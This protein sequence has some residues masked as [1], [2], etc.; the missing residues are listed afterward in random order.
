VG[1]SIP[2]R[3]SAQPN[4]ILIPNSIIALMLGRMQMPLDE[5]DKAYCELTEKLFQ[6]SNVAKKIRNRL[7][8]HD[9]RVDTSYDLMR[10]IRDLTKETPE[11]DLKP[12]KEARI[13]P[14]GLLLKDRTLDSHLLHNKV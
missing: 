14:D 7:Y 2:I 12:I 10:S 9:I 1:R 4:L 3:I 11:F 8:D 6:G 5:V 13:F